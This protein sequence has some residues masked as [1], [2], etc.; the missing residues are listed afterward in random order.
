MKIPAVILAGGLS[1][2]MGRPK[3]L[4][5]IGGIR[6]IDRVAQVVR[7]QADPVL[8]NANDPAIRIDGAETIADRHSGFKGPLA[9]IQAGLAN[10]AARRPEAS[11]ALFVPVDCPF[12]PDDLAARMV[13]AIRSG[14]TIVLARSRGQTHPVCGLWPIALATEL[15]GWL[16]ELRSLRL[17]D[18]LEGREVVTV[19]FD[20]RRIGDELVDPFFN[21]NTPA[22]LAQARQLLGGHY[23][24]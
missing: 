6:L 9:G 11:H 17:W 12:L 23:H 5:V 16:S 24:G 2:R 13:A 14:T 19:D 10:L 3:A 20:D 1:T 15:D 21:V 18:F 22:D 7:A 4:E 8:L